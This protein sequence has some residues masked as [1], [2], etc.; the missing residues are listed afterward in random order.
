MTEPLHDDQARFAVRLWSS[1]KIGSGTWTLPSVGVYKRT[2]ERTLV[3]TEIHA[4]EPLTNLGLFE[5]H[6]FIVRFA[7]TIGWVV[8][9]EIERAY[10]KEHQ[11]LNIPEDAIGRVT[12]C[13]ADCGTVIRVEPVDVWKQYHK[14]E[15]G[16]CPHCGKKGLNKSWEGLHV[17]IDTT[18]VKLRKNEE[19]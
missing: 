4:G 8:Y 1:L 6:D 10:D 14:I 12:V 3:L 16:I 9:E 19:E 11:E 18:S 7:N 13:S 5:H 2:G 15:K 17:V